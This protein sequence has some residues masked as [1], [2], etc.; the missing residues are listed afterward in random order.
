MQKDG[1]YASHLPRVRRINNPVIPQPRTGVE[2]MAL[3]VVLVENRL[4]EGRLLLGTPRAP[5]GFDVVSL[6]SGQHIGR[7]LTPHD[8]GASIGPQVHEVGRVRTPAHAV[9]TRAV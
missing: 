4:L 5:I 2:G 3:L 1:V 6:H 9:V 8:R 7:L